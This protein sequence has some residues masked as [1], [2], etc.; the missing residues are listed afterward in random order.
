MWWDVMIR[1]LWDRQVEAIIGVKLGDAD[2]DSYKYEIM[3]SLIARWETIKK[4]NQCNHYHDQ[5]K[6]FSPFV[7]SVEEI[8]AKEALVIL[9][10]LSL[11]MA[12]KRAEPML[13]VRGWENG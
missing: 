9:S 7:L 11:F 1:V 3:A 5:R 6:H 12:A 4:D 10:Q 13:Q 8:L 2:A